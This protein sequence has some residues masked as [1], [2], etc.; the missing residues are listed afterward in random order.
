MGNTA[1]IHDHDRPMTIREAE[2]AIGSA[3]D[4]FYPASFY[5]GAFQRHAEILRGIGGDSES[6]AKEAHAVAAEGIR[7]VLDALGRSR[8]K[9]TEQ[10]T[11]DAPAA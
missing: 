4:D 2:R 11:L 7:A 10:R 5:I 6:D 8:C 1:R 3:L 9:S